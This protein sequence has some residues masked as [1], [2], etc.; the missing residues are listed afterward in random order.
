VVATC[1][2][3][4]A[5]GAEQQCGGDRGDDQDDG[6]RREAQATAGDAGPWTREH[7]GRSQPGEHVQSG[8][9]C[10]EDEHRLVHGDRVEPLAERG[11]QSVPA[12]FRAD[13]DQRQAGAEQ[14]EGGQDDQRAEQAQQHRRWTGRPVLAATGVIADEPPA[15]DGG[16]QQR[17]RYE[18]DADRDVPADEAGHIHEGDQLGEAQDE[19]DE[20]G[21]RGEPRVAG[22][23]T[24][25]GGDR[26]GAMA[27]PARLSEYVGRHLTQGHGSS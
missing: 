21:R 7:Q 6:Q 13:C 23:S 14:A 26:V 16:L 15:G 24:M 17:R 4:G 12:P 25:A 20:S 19:Q 3:P 27:T 10:P 1:V 18:Q 2:L 5:G 9:E 8:R 22:R 11:Q